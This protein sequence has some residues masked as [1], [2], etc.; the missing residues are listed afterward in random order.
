[1]N[2]IVRRRLEMAARVRLP[3]ALT[4]QAFITAV[5]GMLAKAETQKEL[6]IGKGM[7]ETLLGDLTTAL[8]EFET[9]L[10]MSRTS[11]RDHV[12]ASADLKAVSVEIFDQVRLLSG[13]VRDRFGDNPADGGLEERAE[14]GGAVAREIPPGGG[15]GQEPAKPGDIAPAA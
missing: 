5:K 6:L 4:H 11:R 2:R 15:E 14:R 13:L 9:T 3:K 10:A 12:G 7:S 1:M 8:G